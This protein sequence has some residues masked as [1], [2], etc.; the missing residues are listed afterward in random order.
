MRACD[1][2]LPLPSTR[3]RVSLEQTLSRRRSV[4]EF[5]P[6]S[7]T[8]RQIGQLCWAGQGINEPLEGLRTAP[9]AGALYPIELYV[10][11]ADGVGYFHPDK[12]SIERCITG[13]VRPRLRQLAVNQ[14]MIADAPVTFVIAAVVSRSARKY[15]NRA[16][17][18]CF[19]EAGHVAQ[20][21]LLQA[22]ALR[23]GA[24]PI[25]AFEDRKIAALLKL[26]KGQRV[27][28]LLAVGRL[29]R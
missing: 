23:L 18:Y 29:Q 27:L 9:S 11:T 6:Q 7:L 2:R 1:E 16:E 22:T 24:V 10:V 28:Y 3:G 17:R 13:D 25:G 15:G 20:N 14:H 5:S 21:I 26:P 19:I 12:A 4:R 8:L